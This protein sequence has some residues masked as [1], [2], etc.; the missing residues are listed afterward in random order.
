M[1]VVRLV[2]RHRFDLVQQN[3]EEPGPGEVLARV[4]SV[5]VC[6]SDLH[7]FSEGSVGDAVSVFPMVLGH[8]PAGTVIKTGPGV[9]GWAPGDKALLE[10][11]I[12][13]YHCSFCRAGR[14]NV[15]DNLR[16]LS[17]PEDPG[18]L[19]DY[20]RLPAV[21]LLP[22]PAGMSFPV[23]TL[24]E[25]L[26]IILHSMKFVAL[27]TGENA[28]VFGAGPIG[29]LTVAVLK[30]SGA[31]RVFAVDPVPHRLELARLVGAD[32]IID[33]RETDPSQAIL[34]ETS[35]RG[36]D[37]AVD[38]ATRNGSMDHCFRAARKAGRVVITGIPSEP[39][40]TL[41]FHELRRKE[42]A[43]YNVRRS[44]HESETALELMRDK[45]GLFAPL[46]THELPLEKTQAGFEMLEGYRDGV[47]KLVIS[48]D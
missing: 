18:F 43:L 27:Q 9:T 32:V 47:G 5:G 15:C 34:A 22:M 31:S 14:H 3:I 36:V 30:L 37:A 35:G 48:L 10:P 21:N 2:E 8:E 17:Q 45:P 42:I 24:F 6:G 20:V 4:H 40:V 41:D 38:C 12:Y 44:N 16:F 25:P 19:R 13:C 28:A 7:N 33:P 11:A 39:R 46:V 26:A 29:L 1:R 23:A